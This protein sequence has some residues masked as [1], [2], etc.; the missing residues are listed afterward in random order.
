MRFVV[1]CYGGNCCVVVRF[2]VVCY[3]GNF[4]V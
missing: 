4:C 3:G 2:V 1:M